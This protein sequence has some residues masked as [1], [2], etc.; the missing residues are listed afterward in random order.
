MKTKMIRKAVK[1][2]LVLLVINFSLGNIVIAEEEKQDGY[3]TV[4]D[5]DTGKTVFMT[6]MVV[7]KGDEFLDENNKLYRVTKVK[8]DKGYAEFV[9]KVDL[10]KYFDAE[11]FVGKNANKRI[12]VYFTHNDESYEPTDGTDSVKGRGGI[13]KVGRVL[14]DTLEK[15]GIDTVVAEDV[16]LPHDTAAYK[17]SRRTASKLLRGGV[18][19]LIDIHRDGVPSAEYYAAK[20]AGNYVTQIKLV[21]GRQNPQR[22]VNDNFAKQIKAAADKLYPGLIKGIFYGRGNYNQDLAPRSIILEVGTYKN[23]R[24]SA[25]RAIILFGN[26]LTAA[27]YGRDA[28]K[29]QGPGGTAAPIQGERGASLRSLFLIIL[30]AVTAG[31]LYIVISGGSWGEIKNKINKFAKEEFANLLGRRKNKK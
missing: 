14:E 29:N 5:K 17:R 3:F 6:S 18:D 4:V 11:G 24:E 25:Q 7:H 1:L 9:K 23:H 19:A 31:V 8:G 13:H 30:L 16:H 20:V 10:G 15:K 21:V 26:V 22:Q 28:V 27:L 2:L 12:G